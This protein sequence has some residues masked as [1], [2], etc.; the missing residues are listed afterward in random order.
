[1]FCASADSTLCSV[2]CTCSQSPAAISSRAFSTSAGTN[3][4]KRTL[5]SVSTSMQ[6]PV[7]FFSSRILALPSRAWRQDGEGVVTAFG[8]HVWV[9]AWHGSRTTHAVM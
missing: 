2:S 1:M 9:T 4:P 6:E 7:C 3:Q 5:I 8:G